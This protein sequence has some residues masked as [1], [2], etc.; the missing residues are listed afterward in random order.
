MGILPNHGQTDFFVMAKHLLL[1]PPLTN[2]LNG[3]KTKPPCQFFRKAD[4][5]GNSTNPKDSSNP[6][7]PP[8]LAR[9]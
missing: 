2:P 4:F 3:I 8:Y 9:S 5:I 6:V 7:L 1:L